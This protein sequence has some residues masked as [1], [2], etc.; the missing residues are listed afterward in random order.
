MHWQWIAGCGADAAPYFRIFNPITQSEKFDPD[1]EFIKKWVP[2]LK[3]LP[4]KFVHKPW[5]LPEDI[6]TKIKF[7]LKENYYEPIVDHSEARQAALAAFEHTK[8]K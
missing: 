4:K 6:A 8:K 3:A 2:E 5:E 1:G 7:S